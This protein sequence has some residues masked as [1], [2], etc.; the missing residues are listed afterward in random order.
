[1]REIDVY[2]N[3][4]L[5]N[6]YELQE[7]EYFLFLDEKV[8]STYIKNGITVVKLYVDPITNKIEHQISVTSRNGGKL[9]KT[10]WYLS[11]ELKISIR[12]YK[13]NQILK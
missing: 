7:K 6:G 1:M 5:E 11:N 4:L 9:L 10:Q 3:L 13:I 8:I 2:I 12:E